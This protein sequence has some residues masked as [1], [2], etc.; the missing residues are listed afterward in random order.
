MSVN[1]TDRPREKRQNKPRQV[2]PPPPG[3]RI[4]SIEDL[5]ARG[6]KL[7]TETLRR[8]A[9]A[10]TF[11]APIRLSPGS[12]GRKGWWEHEIDAWLDDQPRWKS[13]DKTSRR[14]SGRQH[15]ETEVA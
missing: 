3:R 13:N 6:I 8:R 9:L 15:S 5:R 12:H 4:L 10:G 11:P 7:D 14:N 2:L 1:V